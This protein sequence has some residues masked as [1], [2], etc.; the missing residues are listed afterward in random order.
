MENKNVN[1]EIKILCIRAGVSLAE[2][3]RRL[4]TTPQ[5]MNQKMRAGSFRV[6]DL[7]KI[8]GVLGYDFFW[9]FRE[10]KKSGNVEK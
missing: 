7:E 6:S 4:G 9:E 2:L 3:S 5:G 10:V 8:A 1:D